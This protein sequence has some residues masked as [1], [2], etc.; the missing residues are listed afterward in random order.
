MN[1]SSKGTSLFAN[2]LIWFGAGVSLAEI[3]TGTY[4]SSMGFGK[5]MLAIIIG[6]IIGAVMMFAA[7]LIGAKEKKSAMETVKMSFGEKGGLFFSAMNVLQLVGW[8]A[9]M[10]YDGALSANQILPIGVPVWA[11]IIGAL[12]IVWILIGIKNL[13]KV[14]IIAMLALFAL[15]LILF[16]LIYGSGSMQNVVVDDS[17]SFG[18]A[19][20]LAV[21]MPLSWLPLISDY[22]REA[23]KPYAATAVS[24]IVY[25]LV[26]IFMYSIGLGAAIFTGES[27][28]AGIMVS[29]G[30]GIAG[31]LI[32][33]FSTVTTTFLDA[34]SGGVSAFSITKKV[35]EKKAAI[36]V[37]VIGTICACLFPMDDITDFLYLIGSVFAPMI[38][39]QIAD[40]FI[41]KKDNKERNFGV[42]NLVIW[43]IGFIIYRAFMRIDIPIGNTLPAMLITVLICVIVSFVRG[44]KFTKN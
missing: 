40:Y 12:I 30:L 20:E 7:G 31:L 44:N 23:E 42:E 16:K 1:N 17:M 24:V 35:S 29:A 4:Y 2:G 39:I 13:G 43:L 19:V 6:H 36:I 5:A 9:I 28:I 33:V 10:A 41:L 37:T 3:L 11:L 21:A 26:S 14:N 27:D 15:S 8:T 32:I 18:A 38:A 22:T 25:S 34:Y